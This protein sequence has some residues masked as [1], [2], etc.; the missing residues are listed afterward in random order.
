MDPNLGDEMG[1]DPSAGEIHTT[2]D[3]FNII[4]HIVSF[5]GSLLGK[6]FHTDS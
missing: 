2:N 5:G 1:C 3:K 4:M 6:E